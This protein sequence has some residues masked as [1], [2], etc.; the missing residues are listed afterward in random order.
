MT[1]PK[2]GTSNAADATNCS[3]CGEALSVGGAPSEPSGAAFVIIVL[4]GIVV[5][6][7]LMAFIVIA[8]TSIASRTMGPTSSGFGIVGVYVAGL[9]VVAAPLVY[10][11]VSPQ[12]QKWPAILRLFLLSV[13]W[14]ALGGLALCSMIMGTAF[15]T[16]TR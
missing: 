8:A 15:F 12:A 11:F 4:A 2:C 13:L 6:F 10:L 1:C 14:V 3:N 16:S 5:G 9:L 7:F